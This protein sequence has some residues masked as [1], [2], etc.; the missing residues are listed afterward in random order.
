V[1]SFIP[2]EKRKQPPSSYFPNFVNFPNPILNTSISSNAAKYKNRNCRQNSSSSMGSTT[3]SVDYTPYYDGSSHMTIPLCQ[4]Y[5]K[6]EKN[7]PQQ[8]HT[9]VF[10]LQQAMRTRAAEGHLMIEAGE[11]NGLINES[12]ELLKQ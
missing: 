3:S 8:L 4:P 6:I 12:F 9:Q 10:N 7:V 11:L 2:L 5:V 1:K